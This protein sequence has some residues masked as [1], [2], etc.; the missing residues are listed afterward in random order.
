MGRDKPSSGE[1]PERSILVNV[2]RLRHQAP[3]C[4]VA[5]EEVVV[6]V[7]LENRDFGDRR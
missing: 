5:V 7:L 1:D 2:Y 3:S 4:A 6:Q